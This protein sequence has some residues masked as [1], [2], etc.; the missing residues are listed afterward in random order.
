MRE[1]FIQTENVHPERK[2]LVKTHDMGWQYYGL[3]TFTDPIQP[4]QNH[5]VKE[6]FAR[7][8]HYLNGWLATIKI[9]Q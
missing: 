5:K 6:F 3:L 8:N 1:S 4:I 9:F 2:W 7:Y